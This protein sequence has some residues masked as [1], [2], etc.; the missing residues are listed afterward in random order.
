MYVIVIRARN[1][2]IP[3]E[4]GVANWLSSLCA[5][6]DEFFLEAGKYRGYNDVGGRVSRS[7]VRRGRHGEQTRDF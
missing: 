3:E 6:I 1:L 2:E 7:C 5:E 4:S